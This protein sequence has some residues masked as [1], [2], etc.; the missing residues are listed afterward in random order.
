MIGI[1]SHQAPSPGEPKDRALAA[2][3]FV[4]LDPFEADEEALE[5]EAALD[6]EVVVLASD[7]STVAL[8]L[9]DIAAVGPIVFAEADRSDVVL[10]GWDPCDQGIAD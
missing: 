3:C 4:V 5:V 10:L 8:V 6:W 2:V 1:S 7:P 9:P